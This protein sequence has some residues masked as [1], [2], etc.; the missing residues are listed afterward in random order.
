MICLRVYVVSNNICICWINYYTTRVYPLI[1]LPQKSIGFINAYPILMICFKIW[2]YYALAS[3]IKE[4]VTLQQERV[5][6]PLETFMRQETVMTFL[7]DIGQAFAFLALN[8]TLQGRRV[9]SWLAAPQVVVMT[10]CGAVRIMSTLGFSGLPGRCFSALGELFK[11]VFV[12]LYIRGMCVHSG[13]SVAWVVLE[14]RWAAWMRRCHLISNTNYITV[15]VC[16]LHPR[17][18][19]ATK[20]HLR[21]AMCIETTLL[22]RLRMTPMLAYCWYNR[23]ATA[24]LFRRSNLE[25]FIS[26][27]RLCASYQITSWKTNRN[28]LHVGKIF[29]FRLQTFSQWDH[30]LQRKAKLP[31]A[32]RLVRAPIPCWIRSYDLYW[33]IAVSF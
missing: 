15:G 5:T 16:C 2:V 17:K 23:N 28:Q 33:A 30:S 24:K 18:C 22:A 12:G 4:N 20:T 32:E 26:W 11:W 25:F 13:I 10:T 9:V 14:I 3:G 7:W 8:A 19:D 27:W 21:S 31:L 29:R 6:G 1:G